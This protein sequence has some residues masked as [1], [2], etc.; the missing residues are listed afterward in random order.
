MTYRIYTQVQRTIY[1][2]LL[3]AVFN[4]L[5]ARAQ[6][7]VSQTLSVTPPLFQISVVPGDLW[8]SSVKVING[9]PYELTVYSEVVNFAARGE[10]GLGRF[11]P[12]MA[13]ELQDRATL[14]SWITVSPG[15]H[16][17][18]PEQS[19]E[20]PL[21]IE[22]PKEA[23]PGGHFAAILIGTQPISGDGKLSLLTSQSVTSL[24]FV[25]VEGNVQEV[26]NI[27]EFRTKERFIDTP[28][29]DVILR[30]ENKGN[31][32]LLPRGTIVI[33]NMWGKERGMISVNNQTQYGNV[34]PDSIREFTFAWKSEYSIT[35]IGRYK[36]V[37]TLAYGE[38]GVKSVSAETYFYVLPL[39]G[40][41]ITL[42]SLIGFVWFVTWAIK[43]YVRRMLAL[44][45]VEVR[46]KKSEI[47]TEEVV[48]VPKKVKVQY[49]TVSAPITAGV[50]D[51]RGRVKA[52]QGSF[53]V[54]KV[55][56]D[57][58]VGYKMFFIVAIVLVGGFVIGVLYIADASKE[59]RPYEVTAPPDS[60]RSL[61]E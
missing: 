41:I 33:T 48:P 47:P 40:T 9:N 55:I 54:V 25:R 39:K 57:F 43:L 14:A 22:A 59:S 7:E 16:V 36:A 51:L 26:G 8:H 19:L 53:E 46:Q 4:A 10:N 12:L 50:V 44:A 2:V 30:F 52:V 23:P 60:I 37:A 61:V 17:I 35:E 32:H 28:Q 42:L 34:L 3:L 5:P 1:I 24:F 31:V 29:T 11:I 45:G 13:E 15:P 58:V 56:W 20:I 38:D 21:F 27:R 6:T 18:P 49:R